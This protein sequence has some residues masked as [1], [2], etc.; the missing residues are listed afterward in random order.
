MVEVYAAVMVRVDQT[1]VVETWSW[2]ISYAFLSA[3]SRFT[4]PEE[5]ACLLRSGSGSSGLARVHSLD[6]ES[7][8]ERC[9][10]YFN[11]EDSGCG[12]VV[13]GG[14]FLALVSLRANRC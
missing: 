10:R 6:G 9:C 13:E 1:Y 8:C 14:L 12:R 5:G 2:M 3:C 11:V 4:Y 7:G